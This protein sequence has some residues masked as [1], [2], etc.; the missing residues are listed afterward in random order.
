[1]EVVGKSLVVT[2]DDIYGG[3]YDGDYVHNVVQK[4]FLPVDH[5]NVPGY[6]QW[7]C[8]SCPENLLFYEDSINKPCRKS[9]D[10]IADA[11]AK[12]KVYKCSKPDISVCP[13]LGSVSAKY[14]GANRKFDSMGVACT[15]LLSDVI[16]DASAVDLYTKDMRKKTGNP[17]WLDDDIMNI[18]CAQPSDPKL[19]PKIS[20]TYKNSTCSNMVASPLCREWAETP[21]GRSLSDRIMREWCVNHTDKDMI[22]GNTSTD[23]TCKCINRSLDPKWNIMQQ[24]IGADAGCWYAPCADK[25]MLNYMVPYDTRHP[26]HC[27]GIRCAIINNYMDNGTINISEIKQGISCNQTPSNPNGIIEWWESL[28]TS[29]KVSLA[30]GGL[31]I[32]A[33]SVILAVLALN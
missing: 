27:D 17:N 25:E 12:Q 22:N 30:G 11:D 26:G 10:T 19:C 29:Q 18:M 31:S 24:Q 7:D 3:K 23:P 6:D 32:L 4:T 5:S 1:M 16:K 9:D 15:Y 8:N 14:A 2:G 13:K 21:T 28:E 20:S 33:G